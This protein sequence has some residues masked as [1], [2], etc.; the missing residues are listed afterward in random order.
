MMKARKKEKTRVHMAIRPCLY[1]LIL[2]AISRTNAIKR[3]THLASPHQ[4]TPSFDRLLSQIDQPICRT[5][6]R[7]PS[8]QLD[9]GTYPNFQSGL[10]AAHLTIVTPT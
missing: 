6:C 2:I 7:L 3:Q 9:L 1:L 10:R 5:S 4:E 8:D